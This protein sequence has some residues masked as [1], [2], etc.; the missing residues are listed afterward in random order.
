MT[1]NGVDIAQLNDI[2]VEFGKAWYCQLFI[3]LFVQFENNF[4]M[5]TEHPYCIMLCLV[6]TY[7]KYELKSSELLLFVL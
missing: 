4:Q 6:L 7:S 1:R 3:I 2:T 5:A